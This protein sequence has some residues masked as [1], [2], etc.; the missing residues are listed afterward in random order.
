MLLTDQES[1]RGDPTAQ[2]WDFQHVAHK[3]GDVNSSEVTDFVAATKL[4]G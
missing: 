3:K 2:I 1:A 4:L